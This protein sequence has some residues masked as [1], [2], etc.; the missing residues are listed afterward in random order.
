VYRRGDAVLVRSELARARDGIT[1]TVPEG[2]DLTKVTVAGMPARL[3]ES[4]NLNNLAVMT[5]TA[6]DGR[7]S[8]I[9]AHGITRRELLDR[10]AE[11]VRGATPTGFRPVYDG[12]DAGGVASVPLPA[13]SR[14]VVTLPGGAR[15]TIESASVP[16]DADAVSWLSPGSVRRAVHGR[17][18]L[19]LDLR[20]ERSLAWAEDGTSIL[21]TSAD[22]TAQELDAVARAIA[23]RPG[24]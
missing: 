20:D 16:F 5:V 6:P 1:W 2:S 10:A 24:R 18:A 7:R 4:G 17:R 22:A 15:V 23:I 9:L 21:L 3:T 8:R 14:T 11:L 12:A 13:R 19:L